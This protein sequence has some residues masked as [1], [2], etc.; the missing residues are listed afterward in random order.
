MSLL[1]EDAS[2]VK[3]RIRGLPREY[4]NAIRRFMISEVP[5]L[6][7]DSVAILDNTSPIYDEVLAHRLGLIPLKADPYKYMDCGG[8]PC[9]V[10]LTLDV[11]AGEEPREVF[12]RELV[13][14]DADVKPV[15]PDIPIAKLAPRQRIK[16]EAYARVGRGKEHAKW[17]PVTVSVLKPYPHVNVLDASSG[18]AREAAAVCLPGV[19]KYS[20]GV[21]KV[22]DE[23]KCRLCMDCVKAC[24]DAVRVEERDDDH[25][26]YVESVGAIEPKRIIYM[27]VRELL[28]QLDELH[29]MVEALGQ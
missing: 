25:V 23:Y 1:E 22:K 7:I 15:S 12:S 26:L 3:V 6:A 9:Q 27:A 13:S 21:L 20:K 29:R 24:P 4:A 19:L 5:T 11:E 17:Q 16:L 2:S 14:E 8:S 28:A 10:L 18:C